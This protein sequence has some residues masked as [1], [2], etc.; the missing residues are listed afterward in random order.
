MSYLSLSR[1]F[2]I[3]TPI[4]L[5]VKTP[6]LF[7]PYIFGKNMLFRLLVLASFFCFTCAKQDSIKIGLNKVELSFLA[8]IAIFFLASCLGIAPYLSLFSNIERFNGVENQVYLFLYLYLISRLL[9]QIQWWEIVFLNLVFVSLLINLETLINHG[10]DIATGYSSL[11]GSKNYL[12]GFNF[13]VFMISIFLYLSHREKMWAKA[14]LAVG[15]LA[16]LVALI[17]FTRAPL[18]G[19]SLAFGLWL[20]CFGYQSLRHKKWFLQAI[21]TVSLIGIRL[22]WQFSDN[23][24]QTHNLHSRLDMWQISLQ[25]FQ[26]FPLLGVGPENFGYLF[27]KYHPGQYALQREQWIDNAHNILFNTLSESGILGVLSLLVMVFLLFQWAF[28]R[29]K[30]QIATQA[31]M[32]ALMMIYIEQLFILNSISQNIPQF[33]IIAYFV[34]DLP[35]VQIAIVEKK[36]FVNISRFMICLLIILIL[37]KSV[38]LETYKHYQFAVIYRNL[39]NNLSKTYSYLQEYFDYP[40]IRSTYLVHKMAMDLTQMKFSDQMPQQAISMYKNLVVDQL[41]KHIQSNPKN[42]RAQVILGG[43]YMRFHPLQAIPMFLRVI[44]QAP[45]K[46]INYVYLA[47]AYLRIGNKELATVYLKL[48]LKLDPTFMMAEKMLNEL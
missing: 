28:Q 5:L 27:D 35:V 6:E 20:I 32:L 10:T 1:L 45:R 44:R 14:S 43:L 39:P 46:P 18:L 4:S 16:V 26:E 15:T 17:T 25:G 34:K 37:Y 30:A 3:L 24:L 41:N 22:I 12:A 38:L 13:S 11:F 19:F 29:S 31:L 9:N 23:L 33:L 48:A 40:P 7:F 47:R 8:Y 21:L 42:I 36:L 2:L